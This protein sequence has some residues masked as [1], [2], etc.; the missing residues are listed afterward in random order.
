MGSV[1]AEDKMDTDFDEET[2]F[3]S[4]S[5]TSSAP[6]KQQ[7]HTF[8]FDSSSS[9][10][11]TLPKSSSSTT[12]FFN[13]SRTRRIS[14]SIYLVLIKAKINILLPFGPLAIFLHYFTG[15]HVW[16]FFFALLGIA[17][18]AERLGYATEQLAFYTGPTG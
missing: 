5:S 12:S 8:H 3:S 6:S 1:S 7:P 11:V 10:S 15:K 13:H 18:L 2:P 16:V 9:S 17:P 4:T 14:R